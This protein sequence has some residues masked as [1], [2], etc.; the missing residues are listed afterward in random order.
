MA[1]LA[2][3]DPVPIWRLFW[4]MGGWLALV[5]GLL[6]FVLTMISQS[7]LTLAER[8]D[9]EGRETAADLIDKYDRVSTDS[10][11]DREVT[12]FLVLR[13]D[14]QAGKTVQVTRSVGRGTYR[15]TAVGDRVPVWYLES[16]PE[17]IELSRGENRT[18]S[19]VARWLAL[20][21]GALTLVA[22]WRPGRK[23]VAAARAR[24][25]GRRET[26]VVTGLAQ[27]SYTVNNRHRY[28]LAWREESGRI[29][30]SLAYKEEDLH[31]YQPGQKIT[32]YQGIERA[33]WSGDVGG[34]DETTPPS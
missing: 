4:R 10:D 18:N 12:Y 2:G 17:T 22:L 33:W 11:G 7:T 13:F 16:A 26:A 9:I 8:F 1:R 21:F 5:F 24:R 31:D 27:T 28:R 15:G 3:S 23:A 14:T 30:E 25:Y 32:V 34:R 6:F 19:I 29:G 20:L